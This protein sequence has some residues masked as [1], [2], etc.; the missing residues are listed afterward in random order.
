MTRSPDFRRMS[1][2]S[3]AFMR[4]GGLLC[5][6]ISLCNRCNKV[7]SGVTVT[8]RIPRPQYLSELSPPIILGLF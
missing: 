6:S 7:N 8:S 5:R 4:F 1:G 3:H 2:P